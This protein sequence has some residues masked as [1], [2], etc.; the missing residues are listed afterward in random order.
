MHGNFNPRTPRGA[1]PYTERREM[2]RPIFQSTHPARGATGY[3]GGSEPMKKIS[4]HAPREGCDWCWLFWWRLAYI[5]IHAP[6]EGCDVAYAL[7]ALVLERF[8]STH[9]A[10]GA[11]AML[12][13][14]PVLLAYISIHAPREGC[15]GRVVQRLDAGGHFNPRT[16]RGVRQGHHWQTVSPLGFQSTH[17]ARGATCPAVSLKRSV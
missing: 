12:E 16:P 6:R 7:F 5:S 4:I 9:P 17:P 3:S 15:D 10:R 11:T 13:D 14:D 8:Q 2:N 1:R